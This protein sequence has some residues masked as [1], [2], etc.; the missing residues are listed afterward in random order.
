MEIL[1]CHELS[2]NCNGLPASN[3]Y[4]VIYLIM[5]WLN[6]RLGNISFNSQLNIFLHMKPRNSNHEI[7]S[8]CA[9]L[10]Q[11][12]RTKTLWANTVHLQPP[13]QRL[14]VRRNP[15]RKIKAQIR[16]K[17]QL[18]HQLPKKDLFKGLGC[19]EGEYNINLKANNHCTIQP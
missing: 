19:V 9:N 5:T 8:A 15:L 18:D 7:T 1:L 10:V 12:L 13:L 14:G 16:C 3:K 6:S 2:T 4:I 17:N 11:A